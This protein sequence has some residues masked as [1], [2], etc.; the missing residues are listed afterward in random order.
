MLTKDKYLDSFYLAL[1]A[2]SFKYL[3]KVE[4]SLEMLFPIF[5][6]VLIAVG[7]LFFMKYYSQAKITPEGLEVH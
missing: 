5:S 6:T 2:V 4:W 7:S 1:P 3:P